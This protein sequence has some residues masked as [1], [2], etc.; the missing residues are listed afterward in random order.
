[1]VSSQP[2][3]PDSCED[4]VTEENRLNNTES[5]RRKS[6][7]LVIDRT[8]KKVID[9]CNKCNNNQTMKLESQDRVSKPVGT[10]EDIDIRANFYVGRR[11]KDSNVL[12]SSSIND[13]DLEMLCET[14]CRNISQ[15]TEH[16][17]SAYKPDEIYDSS[18]NKERELCHSDLNFTTSERINSVCVKKND[19]SYT[20]ST[21]GNDSKLAN[22]IQILEEEARIKSEPN[23]LVPDPGDMMYPNAE[24]ATQ[25]LNCDFT[26][27]ENSVTVSSIST[28]S[29]SRL[30]STNCTGVNSINT[31]NN[32]GDNC[33]NQQS[34]T[35]SSALLPDIFCASEFPLNSRGDPS[36]KVH[37]IINYR[38]MRNDLACSECGQM[39][40]KTPSLI[41]HKVRKHSP[42]IFECL[43]C[44]K[45]YGYKSDLDKHFRTHSGEKPYAC[46]VCGRGFADSGNKNKHE[47]KCRLHI[48]RLSMSER[49]NFS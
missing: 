40:N 45:K 17:K 10:E 49:D 33:Y 22:E 30:S 44:A 20:V 27:N 16:D 21:A 32:S 4:N 41:R 37:R 8:D 5:Q 15:D 43:V 38:K 7:S 3:P 34:I 42:Q 39:F 36:T 25:S 29:D 9:E 19:S 24:S 12:T 2:C 47:C 26:M 46:S 23:D 35:T 13:S 28:V 11:Q 14:V 1:M 6:P 48:R 18:T 31:L